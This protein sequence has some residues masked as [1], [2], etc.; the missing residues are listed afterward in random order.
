M[1]GFGAFAGANIRYWLACFVPGAWT[2]AGV[3]V[4]GSLAIG[5]I[6]AITKN[7]ETDSPLRLLLVVG[8]LGGFTTFSAFSLQVIEL[9]RRE[10]YGAAVIQ[11]VV[12]SLGSIVACGL[13]FFLGSKLK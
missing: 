2:T 9:I 6:V 13:G 12:Q 5:A 11:V 1:V 3:N 7:H 8:L 10:E 4:V